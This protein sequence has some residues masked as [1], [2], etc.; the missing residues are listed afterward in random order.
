MNGPI[1]YWPERVGLD[2]PGMPDNGHPANL[3]LG[4]T[5]FAGARRRPL[6]KYAAPCTGIEMRSSQ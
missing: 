4:S 5:F 2:R 6:K 3:G 1:L